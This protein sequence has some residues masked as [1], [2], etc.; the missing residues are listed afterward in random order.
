MFFC[1]ETFASI[2]IIWSLSRFLVTH[3]SLRS[4][5]HTGY[6]CLKRKRRKK[7]QHAASPVTHPPACHKFMTSTK[8]VDTLSKVKDLEI[9]RAA[10]FTCDLQTCSLGH[11]VLLMGV[12]LEYDSKPSVVQLSLSPFL[13][14]TQNRALSPS[15]VVAQQLRIVGLL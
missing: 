5:E 11:I 15:T 12:F 2:Q 13:G 3:C 1:L 7:N 4:T 8:S 14:L 9:S 10:A 6:D